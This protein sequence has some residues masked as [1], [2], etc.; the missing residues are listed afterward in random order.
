M[1]KPP[2]FSVITPSYNQ[3]EF[4]AQ[5]IESVLSQAGD[6]RIDYIIVDGGSTDNSVEVIKKFETA[7][8]LKQRPIACRGIT[9]RWLSEKDRGQTDALMKGFAM[10]QGEILAWLNSDDCYLPG[11]LQAAAEHFSSNPETALFYGDAHY[12]DA[13]GAILGNYRTEPFEFDKLARFNF[14]CQPSTFFGRQVFDAVGGLDRSLHFAMDY[15]L[16][17]RLG[18]QYP[19]SYLPQ[20]LSLYRLHEGSKTVRDETLFQNSEEALRLARKYFGWAPLTRVYN[21]CDFSCRSRLP[22]LF[23]RLKPVRIAVTLLCSVLRSLV[24][25]RGIDRRDLALFNRENISKVFKSRLEIMT[26]TDRV[27]R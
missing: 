24:L 7:L 14:I 9:L 10:A 27:M 4:L 23:V 18:R 26:G 20:T 21:S 15:D 8:N 12:C 6:F 25:N 11:A 19:V 2:L 1:N 17:I 16:W 3:G 13:A 5:T 22:R